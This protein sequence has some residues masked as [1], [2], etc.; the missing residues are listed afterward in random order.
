[1]SKNEHNRNDYSPI[2]SSDLE[3]WMNSIE[4]CWQQFLTDMA[5]YYADH[6]EQIDLEYAVNVLALRE[7]VERIDQRKDY[8]TRYHALQ[9]SEFKEIG[10]GM[11]WIIKLKPFY[12]K[13]QLNIEKL[14]FNI[15]ENFALYHMLTSLNN[16]A[17]KLKLQYDADK[18]PGKLYDE[19]LY[20]LTFR[21][22]SKESMGILAELVA[23]IV[24]PDL[25]V[26]EC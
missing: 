25:P 13:N 24:I 16:L 8:F 14:A 12:L 18:L 5:K 21:D 15:N 6:G 26:D 19:L 9:M 11:F 7:L 23:H 10:L 2:S 20:S 17:K 1:M 4:G 3:K 22:F